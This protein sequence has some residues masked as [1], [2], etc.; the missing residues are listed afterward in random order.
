[1]IITTKHISRNQQIAILGEEAIDQKFAEPI[2][3]QTLS[4]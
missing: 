2:P 1:M 4:A 3:L